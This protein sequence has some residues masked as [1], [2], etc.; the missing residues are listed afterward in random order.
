MIMNSS[1]RA[2]SIIVEGTRTTLVAEADSSS[3]QAPSQ[4]PRPQ[5]GGAPLTDPDEVYIVV[6]NSTN[7]QKVLNS[8]SGNRQLYG[9]AVG[10]LYEFLRCFQPFFY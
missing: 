10:V 1:N 8:N 2:T 6:N 4:Q 5:N 9:A 3:Q 7:M